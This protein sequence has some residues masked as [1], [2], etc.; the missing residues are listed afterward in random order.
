[1][2]YQYKM[3]QVPPTITIEAGTAQGNEAA[4]YLE[5]VVNQYAEKGWE[6]YSVE[7]IGVHEKPGCWASLWGAKEVFTSHYVITFRAGSK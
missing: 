3:V 2:S 7:T 5:R 1:M 6:F 4:V